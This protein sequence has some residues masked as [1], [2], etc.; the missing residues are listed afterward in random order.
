M[1][2]IAIPSTAE[3][4]NGVT[5]QV[6]VDQRDLARAEARGIDNTT[7]HSYVRFLVWAA[8]TRTKQYVGP[9]EMFNET[10]CVEASDAGAEVPAGDE[11]SLDPGR[12]AQSATT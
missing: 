12:K 1:G 11:G 7:R 3:M 10:D 2:T 9:W 8:L 5:L 6:V 4:D